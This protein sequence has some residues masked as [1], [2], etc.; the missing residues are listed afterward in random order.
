MEIIIGICLYLFIIAGSVALGKFS[1]E[2]DNALRRQK[3]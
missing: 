1:K 2:T 3:H